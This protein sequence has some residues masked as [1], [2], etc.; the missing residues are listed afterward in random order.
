MIILLA[1]L[2]VGVGLAVASLLAP[3]DGVGSS[4]APRPSRLREALGF[5]SIVVGWGPWAVA[6]LVSMVSTVCSTR[7]NW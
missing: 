4:F 3:E 6:L 2:L 7:L 1:Y 5:V